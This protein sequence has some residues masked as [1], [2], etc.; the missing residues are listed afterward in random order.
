MNFKY[1]F[2]MRKHYEYEAISWYIHSDVLRSARPY[3][4][5]QVVCPKHFWKLSSYAYSR[6]VHVFLKLSGE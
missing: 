6:Q 2:I 4:N 5:V 3:H 1:S